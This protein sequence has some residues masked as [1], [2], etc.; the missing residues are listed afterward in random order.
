MTQV[1]WCKLQQCSVLVAERNG[2]LWV[3]RHLCV[4]NSI[5]IMNRQRSTASY[6]FIPLR[7]AG[8]RG[9]SSVG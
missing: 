8:S 2:R 1:S 7:A 4:S 5:R 6:R 3:C 9:L